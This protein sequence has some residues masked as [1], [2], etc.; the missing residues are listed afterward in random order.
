MAPHP[1]VANQPE[2][3]P[4]VPLSWHEL[5]PYFALIPGLDAAKTAQLQQLANLVTL[6]ND[7]VN[8]ISRKDIQHLPERHVLYS[9]AIARHIQFAP[10]TTVLDLGTGGGFP[11]M[12]LAV[13][14]PQVQFTLLDSTQKKLRVIQEIAA[15]LGLANVNTVWQRAE[16]HAPQYDFVTGRAV[17]DLRDFF[18]LAIKRVHCRGRNALPNGILYLKGGELDPELQGI[19]V[20]KTVVHKLSDWLPGAYFQTKQ[21]VYLSN[22]G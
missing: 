16:E 14:F 18:P 4:D 3:L 10:G 2:A 5:A 7:R 15:E 1:P 17:A 22:C 6:W 12:P 11:G 13:C 20:K 8:V 9:L 19:R 21:L